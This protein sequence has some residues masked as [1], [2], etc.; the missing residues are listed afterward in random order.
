VSEN[1]ELARSVFLAASG[2]DP[3][4]AFAFNDPAIEVDMSGVAGWPEKAVYRGYTEVA[5]FFQAWA[6]SWQDWHFDL[7]EV[8]DASHEQVFVAL[9]EWG[10]GAGSG[11][12][13]D[14]HRYFAITIRDGRAVRIRMFSDRADALAAL[15]LTD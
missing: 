11:A 8:R 9:H 2:G 4:A 10:T 15:G 12:S 6:D 5:E 13:V 7:E 1:A 3:A 14:Q